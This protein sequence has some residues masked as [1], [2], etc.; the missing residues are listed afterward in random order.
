MGFDVHH[1]HSLERMKNHVGEIGTRTHDLWIS[2]PTHVE[3]V[4]RNVELPQSY[5]KIWSILHYFVALVKTA[6]FVGGLNLTKKHFPSSMQVGC[7]WMNKSPLMFW[8][9][10]TYVFCRV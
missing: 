5:F 8:T 7:A 9:T 2:D 6:V 10:L 3:N 1:T 4:C